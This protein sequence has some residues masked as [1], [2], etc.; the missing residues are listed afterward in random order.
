ML[1]QVPDEPIGFNIG[2]GPGTGGVEPCSCIF[3][4]ELA[5]KGEKKSHHG[6]SGRKKIL[7]QG[8]PGLDDLAKLEK[9]GVV[10]RGKAR[11]GS[12]NRSPWAFPFE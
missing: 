6:S 9:E 8:M 5:F 3:F 11:Q 2:H 7:G 1:T 12:F 4:L 10:G